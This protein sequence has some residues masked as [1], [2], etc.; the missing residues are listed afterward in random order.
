M[1]HSERK[2]RDDDDGGDNWDCRF[3]FCLFVL[4]CFVLLFTHGKFDI[5]HAGFAFH[6]AT[7]MEFALAT[8]LDLCLNGFVTTIATH[9]CTSIWTFRFFFA[10]PSVGSK[11]SD[12][13]I[14]MTVIRRS[15]EKHQ[16]VGSRNVTGLSSYS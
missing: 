2:I 9:S 5:F 13:V 12:G 10:N 7:P 3:L 8:F 16:V 14:D 1:K 15:M 11:R 4:F 6:I